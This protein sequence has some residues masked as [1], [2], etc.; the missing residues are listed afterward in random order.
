MKGIFCKLSDSNTLRIA[1]KYS[2]P[3]YIVKT[4]EQAIESEGHQDGFTT[5]QLVEKRVEQWLQAVNTHSRIESVEV[6][7]YSGNITP[8]E[9]TVFVFGS[10]PEEKH[11]KGAAK[12]AVDKFGAK[13]GQGEGLYGSSYALPTKRI[14]IRDAIKLP[15]YTNYN[16]NDHQ[17]PEILSSNTTEAIINGEITAITKYESDG[18]MEDW[19]QVKVGDI[20]ELRSEKTSIFV[21]VTKPL[22]KLDSKIDAEEWSKKEGW[23]TQYFNQ[24]VKPKIEQAYQM[25]FKYV[26]A[27]GERTVTPK[28]IIQ[29]IKK[30]YAV[31]ASNPTKQFK[32]GYRNKENDI[33][34]NG[35]TGREMMNMFLSAGVIPNNIVFS[36]EWANNNYFK[37][38]YRV[39]HKLSGPFK[40]YSKDFPRLKQT[41]KADATGRGKLIYAQPGSGKTTVSDNINIIDGDFILSE[42]LDCPISLVFDAWSLIPADEWVDYS[43]RYAQ[44]IEQYIAAGKTVVASN[45]SILPYAD[46]I[47]YRETAKEILEQTSKDRANTAISEANALRHTTAVNEEISKRKDKSTI[48]VLKS[49]EYLGDFLLENPEYDGGSLQGQA[50]RRSSELSLTKIIQDFLQEFGIDTEIGAEVIEELDVTALNRIVKANTVEDL[51]VAAGKQLALMS[52]YHEKMKPI[53][54]EMIDRK[55]NA[56]KGSEKSMFMLNGKIKDISYK[57]ALAGKQWMKYCDY[58]GQYMGQVLREEYGNRK[59]KTAKNS[60]FIDKIIEIVKDIITKLKQHAFFIDELDSTCRTFASHILANNPWYF[61]SSLKKPGSKTRAKLVDPKAVFDAYPTEA[62]MIKEF[63]KNNIYLAGSLAVAFQ[64]EVY[65]P[66]ENPVHDLDFEA[67]FENQEE[68]ES[69]LYSLDRFTK[70]NLQL[71]TIIKDKEN[72]KEGHATYTYIYLDRPYVLN[73]IDQQNGE[74]LDPNTNETLAKYHKAEL[75]ILADNTYGKILDFFVRGKNVKTVPVTLNDGAKLKITYW[76][77]ALKYKIDWVRIKDVFDYNR[78]VT[79]EFRQRAQQKQNEILQEFDVER[80]Q[81]ASSV[82]SYKKNRIDPSVKEYRYKM[83]ARDFAIKSLSALNDT[84]YALERE[85]D[86]EV[87]DALKHKKVALLQKLKE[88]KGLLYFISHYPDAIN[89]VFQQVKEDYQIYANTGEDMLEDEDVL[90]AFPTKHP[91]GANYVRTQLSLIVDNFDSVAE[92]A[93]TDIE[94]ILGVRVTLNPQVTKEGDVNLIVSAT[95]DENENND[96]DVVNEDEPQD[97]SGGNTYKVR[98]R[99]NYQTLTT[100]IK[101]IISSIPLINEFGELIQDDLG[102]TQYLDPRNT[103]AILLDGLSH[104]ISSEDFCIKQVISENQVQFSYPALEKLAKKYSWVNL[105]I[106]KFNN[107]PRLI[108]AFYGAYRRDF[109]PRFSYNQKDRVY[110]VNAKSIF[111]L[112]WKELNNRLDNGIPVNSYS[113]Y[114][115]AGINRDKIKATIDYIN[116]VKNNLEGFSSKDGRTIAAFAAKIH[117][118][119]A[120][121]GLQVSI[122]SIKDILKSNDKVEIKNLDRTLKDVLFILDKINSRKDKNNNSLMGQDTKDFYKTILENLNIANDTHTEQTYRENGATHSSYTVPGYIETL[123]KKLKT[124]KGAQLED[125]LNEEFKNIEGPFYKNGV[126]LNKILAD[127]VNLKTRTE[128]QNNIYSCEL[129]SINKKEYKNWTTEDIVEGFLSTY[130]NDDYVDE[131][132]V[133]VKSKYALFNAPIFSDSPVV[134]FFKSKR[135]TSKFGNLFNEMIPLFRDVV[136]QELYRIQHVEKRQALIKQGLV[137]EI[138]N[139]DNIGQQFLYFTE[140]NSM[141]EVTEQMKTLLK[142]QNMNQLNALIDS[143]IIPILQQEYSQWKENLSPEAIIRVTDIITDKGYSEDQVNSVLEE[144][145]LNQSFATSQVI[146]LLVTDPAYFKDPVEFQ[147]RFKEV[148]AAG[149]KPCTQTEFG[150]KMQ[151]SVYLKDRK[152]LSLALSHIKEILDRAVREGRILPMDRDNILYKFNKITATDGQALRTL[153]S[154]KKLWDMLGKLEEVETAIDRIAKGKWDMEDFYTI[155]QTIKPFVFSNI[156]KDDG[157]NN[158]MRV[159][160]QQKD[161][162]FILLLYSTI[163]LDLKGNTEAKAIQD[164][165]LAND[166]DIVVLESAVKTGAQGVIDIYNTENL[167]QLIKNQEVTLG[168]KTY[169]FSNIKSKKDLL[170]YL[171]EQ[172]LSGKYTAQEVSD[173]LKHIS[174]SYQE[175]YNILDQTVKE[176]NSDGKPIYDENGQ[177]I[178]KNEYIHEIPYDDYCITMSTE[179]DHLTDSETIYGTQFNTLISSDITEDIEI[180]L[181][182]KTFKG[183]EIKQLYQNLRIAN[184][185]ESAAEVREIFENPEVLVKEVLSRVDSNAKYNKGIK[186]AIKLVTRKDP[187]TGNEITTFNFPTNTPAFEDQLQEIVLSIAKNKITKQK[188]KGGTAFLTSDIGYTD[189]LQTQYTVDKDGNKTIDYIPCFMPCAYKEMFKDLLVEK[190]EG[191]VTYYELDINKKDEFGEYILDRKLLDMIGYRIPTEHK[192]SIAPLRVIGFLPR[193]N[194]SS[195]MLPA[196]AVVVLSGAD[197]DIDKMFLMMHEYYIDYYNKR[198]AKKDFAKTYRPEEEFTTW[199]KQNKEQYRRA[200]P[201]YRKVKYDY[202]KNP[203]ENTRE[204]RNNALIDLSLAIMKNH[205]NTEAMHKPQG[206]DSFVRGSLLVNLLNNQD[207]INAYPTENIVSFLSTASIEQLKALNKQYKKPLPLLSPGNFTYFHAQNMAGGNTLG[208]FAN[209]TTRSAKYQGTGLTNKNYFIFNG[210]PVQALDRIYTTKKDPTTGQTAKVLITQNCCEGVG[211]CADNAKTPTISDTRQSGGAVRLSGYLLS[212]GLSAEDVALFFDQPIIRDLLDSQQ[213]LVDIKEAYLE[214]YKEEIKHVA[215]FNW[216]AIDYSKYNFTTEFLIKQAANSRKLESLSKAEL[217]AYHKWNFVVGKLMAD[218]WD[219]ATALGEITGISRCDSTNGAIGHN[220]AI[221][222]TQVYAVDS[223]HEKGSKDFYPLEGLSGV[224]INLGQD[225]LKMSQEELLAE[226]NKRGN[227]MLQAYYTYGIE[228][229]IQMLKSYFANLSDTFQDQI[230]ELH[231]D[232]PVGKLDAKYVKNFAK[233]YTIYKLGTLPLFRKHGDFFE[234][235][236][237]YLREFPKKFFSILRE[238]KKDIGQLEILKRIKSVRKGQNQQLIIPDANLITEIE[239]NRLRDSMEDLLY[240]DNPKAIELAEDLFAYSYYA[241]SLEFL[242]T[243]FSRFFN[244]AFQEAM[245]GYKNALRQA[246][247]SMRKGE[248]LEQFTE[249]WRN[250]HLTNA[251]LFSTRNMKVEDNVEHGK[252][253]TTNQTRNVYG[254]WRQYIKYKPSGMGSEFATW[255]LLQLLHGDKKEATYVEVPSDASISFY[256]PDISI[257]ESIELVRKQKEEDAKNQEL[258]KKQ[259]AWFARVD[260]EYLAGGAEMSSEDFTGID[261]LVESINS[262]EDQVSQ[263]QSFQGSDSLDDWLNSMGGQTNAQESAVYIPSFDTMSTETNTS[264]LEANFEKDKTDVFC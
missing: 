198:A 134:K 259:N 254:E 193:Q 63:E 12:A 3:E 170:D 224:P 249:Y 98:Q 11:G 130:L 83:V 73:V 226:F 60:S 103:H 205:I 146:Q 19:N 33:T 220:T 181:N 235:R 240:L 79:Q 64:G 137:E 97:Y 49:D 118:A 48:K 161:S 116:Q 29:N 22:T 176:T 15:G 143:T 34:L 54:A 149:I 124:Y 238:N 45:T 152:D 58:I 10:N 86:D 1:N 39:N 155:F 114:D 35:Y 202:T 27:N 207:F 36:E 179:K 159:G 105:L 167:K 74:L 177:V 186:E 141:T 101:E 109:I 96:I 59:R 94:N 157:L 68:L 93:L 185:A 95:E 106:E 163:A 57:S 61:K 72:I 189:Q 251:V 112:S 69:T 92:G 32:I 156:K 102:N 21:E 246:E 125:F 14:E 77:G 40:S 223:V 20:V 192:Y 172:Q 28:E 18:N 160:H 104:M 89:T 90:D 128:A 99:D 147:K 139:Y 142:E 41:F 216:D 51:P 126:W 88:D 184:L 169:K 174:P 191:N 23:D 244:E 165:M 151:R 37:A 166:I 217:E 78:F 215:G 2:V 208:A 71:K 260:D 221:A 84:I 196:D 127:I 262:G 30:L 133:L 17:R 230:K 13:Y 52:L 53:V 200:T 199:Y 38:A 194:G 123:F 44:R 46:Y 100:K 154:V 264:A 8:Q 250:N 148:Y 120:T 188:I 227:P 222:S 237:Y 255:K 150:T 197:F 218:L 225:I 135:Y 211:A 168:N 258:E 214:A 162:E 261:S 9:D 245:P 253:Y 263:S 164:F 231:R 4:I 31:A 195:I 171:F 5:E 153:P 140:L 178:W 219:A 252:T 129:S 108:G 80:L 213:S 43:K 144:Y 175:A 56:V 7:F 190:Q 87:S 234:S 136:K 173:I 248:N 76:E 110:P 239:A 229:P 204:Q 180:T 212:A 16:F 209:N 187:N 65:R 62:L 122:N 66:D 47:V 70:D 117:N 210:T 241:H 236:N 121:V 6:P 132:G 232:A 201:L 55:N 183:R 228:M 182:G 42:I 107:N 247:E 82:V 206:F 111:S 115:A 24:E 81:A 233:K 67:A 75:T 158:K 257:A 242:P 243:S 50:N 85:I 113:I 131:K 138:A 256:N 26:G 91:N 203:S 119:Y 145:Y 25:E